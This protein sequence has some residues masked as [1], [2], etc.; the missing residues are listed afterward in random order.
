VSGDAVSLDIYPDV[1]RLAHA[2][3]EHVSTL[4]GEAIAA[5]GRAALA[6]AGGATPRP[7]Y[8]ALAR[9]EIARRIDWV[10]VH[11][12]WGDERCVPPGDPR[13]N[14]RMAR[15][16]LLDAV[17]VPPQQI[18]RI[19]C[20]DGE[21][22][23]AAAVYERTLRVFFDAPDAAAP[24]PGS[25]FDLVLLGMGA[26]GHTASLFPGSPA[27]TENSRWVVAQRIEP[28]GMWRITLTPVVINAARNV[29]FVVT[30]AAKAERLRQVLQV[31]SSH[32][33]LPA[34]LVRPSRGQIRWFV[35][36]DAARGLAT[37]R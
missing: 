37:S 21:P 13:S 6:L 36:A 18:H 12:F 33:A 3:A 16:T 4:A 8:E 17:P 1:A 22:A 29:V 15:D 7:V 34:Q 31:P 35:D 2:A 30:G 20:E 25:G 5:R 11:V 24:A 9:P 23:R 14:Y 27:L 10:R 26:D 32:D 19:Q 28:A